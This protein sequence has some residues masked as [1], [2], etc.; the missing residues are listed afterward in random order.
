MSNASDFIIENGV[1]TKYVG[2]GG[3]VLIP[4]AVTAIG[5]SAFSG[6]K[7][8]R[9][10]TLPEAVEKIGKEAFYRSS[11]EAINLPEGLKSIGESAFKWSK[12]SEIVVPASI[13]A[14]GI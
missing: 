3:D 6:N 1:L 2:P 9:K 10:V 13:S 4:D 12:L 11:L 14:I 7:D 8:I 5:A